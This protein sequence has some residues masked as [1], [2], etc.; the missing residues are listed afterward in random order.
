LTSIAQNPPQPDVA[1]YP[2]SSLYPY[3]V[4]NRASYEQAFIEQPP[5]YD[6]AKPVKTWFATDATEFKVYNDL[7]RQ[8]ESLK[9][10]A[11]AAASV[12]IPGLYRYPTYVPPTNTA[13]FL[14]F[15]SP[16]SL[17]DPTLFAREAD[18]DALA[19][20]LGGTVEEASAAS[21]APGPYSYQSSDSRIYNIRIGSVDHPAGQ[22]LAQFYRLGIGH[23]GSW[24]TS[25]PL[26][27]T[28]AQDFTNPQPDS[29]AGMP[30][31]VRPLLANEKLLI[32]P[33]AGV[34]VQRTDKQVASPEGG[35]F[36]DADRQALN[37]V[38]AMLQKVIAAMR[39]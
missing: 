29:P 24:S 18:A 17:T 35:S 6:P 12:N 37:D 27:F 22:L 19:A 2:L 21:P 34:L 30:I 7:T 14:F 36:T 4:Y 1:Q 33:F 15:S 20:A 38:H 3:P 26:M 28:P 11:A 5:R 39:I 31:P 23:P 32:S 16:I 25:G 9:L 8:V 10:D 13:T